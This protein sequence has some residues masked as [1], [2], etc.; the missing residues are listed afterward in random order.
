VAANWQRSGFYWTFRES[1]LF[2]ALRA[3]LLKQADPLYGGSAFV[4]S[5][6]PD[7]RVLVEEAIAVPVQKQEISG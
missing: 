4:L 5:R 2:V 3:D 7:F 1:R 6:E